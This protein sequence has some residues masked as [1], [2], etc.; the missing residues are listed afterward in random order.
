MRLIFPLGP[1]GILGTIRIRPGTL[2]R[3]RRWRAKLRSIL[4]ADLGAR[5]Q[6]HSGGNVLAKSLCGMETRRLRPHRRGQECLFDFGGRDLLPSSF[7]DLLYSP[8]DEQISVPV[9][10]SEIAGA[11]PAVSKR[12][13]S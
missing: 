7:D 12:A 3:A 11:E 9:Q 10:I 5:A 8:D 2:N 6:D 1:F 13:I 4:R